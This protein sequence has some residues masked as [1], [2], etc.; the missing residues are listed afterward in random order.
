MHSINGKN[1][2]EDYKQHCDL[3]KNAETVINKTASKESIAFIFGKYA[4]ELKRFIQR[5]EAS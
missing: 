3:E 5:W 4:A 1:E 2:D